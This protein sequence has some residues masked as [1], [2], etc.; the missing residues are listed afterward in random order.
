MCSWCSRKAYC[1]TLLQGFLTFSIIPIRGAT[2]LHGP[3]QGAQKSTNTGTSLCIDT[4]WEQKHSNAC[5]VLVGAEGRCR[6]AAAA[7]S[8]AIVE[9]YHHTLCG[10]SASMHDHYVTPAALP[11]FSTSCSNWASLV[12]SVTATTGN[13]RLTTHLLVGAERMLCVSAAPLAH[14]ACPVDII[15]KGCI[16]V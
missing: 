7:G 10:T 8:N 16:H 15:L 13:L 3:H 12:M 4:M 11:T 1:S 6:W 2:S 5:L 14:F 9:V